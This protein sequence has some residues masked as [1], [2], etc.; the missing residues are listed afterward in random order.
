[1]SKIATIDW[2][3]RWGTS[4]FSVNFLSHLLRKKDLMLY[5]PLVSGIAESQSSRTFSKVVYKASRLWHQ[6]HQAEHVRYPEHTGKS[7]VDLKAC[8]SC[9]SNEKIVRLF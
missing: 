4:V 5:I 6:S 2:F 8:G 3:G 9:Q 1:M 7:A